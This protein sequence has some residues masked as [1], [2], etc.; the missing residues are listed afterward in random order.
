[1]KDRYVEA[2]SQLESALAGNGPTWLRQIRSSAI[3][4]FTELGFPTPRDEAWRFTNVQPITAVPFKR[5]TA[6]RLNGLSPETLAE[7][8]IPALTACRLVFVDG[9]YTPELSHTQLPAGGT[10]GSLAAWLQNGSDTLQP[11]LAR[12]VGQEPH[13]FAALNTAFFSDGAFVHLP[14]D[15]VLDHP[16]HLLF[17]STAQN[18]PR[19]TYPR[20]LIVAEEN[21]KASVVESYVGFGE[22]VY[23]TNAVTEVILGENARVDHYKLQRERRT[24]FHVAAQQVHQHRHSTLNSCSISL[25]GA[26]V[27]NDLNVLLAAEGAE[28]HLNG[29]YLVTGTQHV[30]NHTT[31]D[32][33]KPHGSS[34][35]FYKGILDGRSSAVFNGTIVV[36]PGAQKTDAMQTNKNL[37]LSDEGLVHT[38]PELQ[39]FAN[40]VKCKHGATIGKLSADA[41]FYL[42]SR[43]IDLE[44][45]R[46]LLI[47]AFA[48]EIIERI[49]LRSLK[50]SIAALVSAELADRWQEAEHS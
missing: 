3:S 4:R 21:A 11:H 34:R 26:L 23:L 16:I 43:G 25:G 18:K 45:A 19:V 7:T 49:P 27:R 44:A 20:V 36:R 1:M 5:A 22:G 31:I 13:A 10:L 28:C 8:P 33:A 15:V 40:D 35:E 47:H 41:L 38:K 24:A 9:R 46:R 37:L 32:H 12:Q 6:D 39:I 29:L 42:R 48:S 2:F 14:Q 30:D 50:D 17:V